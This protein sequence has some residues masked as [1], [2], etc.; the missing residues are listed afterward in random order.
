MWL[1]AI[2]RC[3]MTTG[4]WSAAFTIVADG[5]QIDFME[6]PEQSRIEILRALLAG[7]TEGEFLEMACPH[8]N[9]AAS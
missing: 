9:R 5:I 6:L 2:M 3:R 4:R 1:T 8:P 7:K